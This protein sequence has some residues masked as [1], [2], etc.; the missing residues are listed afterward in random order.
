MTKQYKTILDIRRELCITP[1]QINSLVKFLF[2]EKMDFDVYLPSIGMNLQRDLVW[3]IDQKRELI[4]SILIKRRIPRMA[5]ICTS[6]ETYQVIDGKQRL[7]AMFDFYDNKFTL[8]IEGDELLFSELPIDYQRIIA[9]YH[10]PYYIYHEYS[11]GDVSDQDKIDWFKYINF[12]G[13]PQ[14]AKHMSKLNGSN[15]E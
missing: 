7:S 4:W 8:N 12:A 3:T 11:Q 15:V 13:T 1:H 6:D 2:K 14:E 10:I 5:M 9:S